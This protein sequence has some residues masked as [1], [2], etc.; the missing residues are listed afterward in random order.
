M[1]I[2]RLSSRGVVALLLAAGSGCV[3]QPQNTP[4]GPIGYVEPGTDTRY[5]IYVPSNYTASRTWPL[6]ITLH[7]THG[8]DSYGGQIR[9]WKMLAEEFGFLV[10]A[11]QLRSTQGVLPRIQ[12]LWYADLDRDEQSILAVLRDVRRL[13]R[14]DADS[15]LL[16]GFS[17]GGY[18]LIWTGLQH[19]DK[20]SML[21]ARS[22]TFDMGMID[23]IPVTQPARRLPV[24]ILHGTWDMAGGQ[25]SAG[26]TRLH[27][28]GFAAVERTLSGGHARR[29][30]LALAVWRDHLAMRDYR[31]D[32]A[33]P[34]G[35]FH[36]ASAA[37]LASVA[38]ASVSDSSRPAPRPAR[39]VAPR[40]PVRPPSPARAGEQHY[41][42]RQGDTLW[43]IAQSRLGSGHRW[44]QLAT[45]NPTI[46]P[47]HLA[48]GQKL[49]LPS[50]TH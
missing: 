7:G 39:T 46:Q 30:D 41:V 2:R 31:R 22:C 26:A 32:K 11:P 42:V 1:S 4:V 43:S 19:P 16:T 21:I 10:A 44:R 13:Y 15:V 47:E 17:A 8:F 48:V 33:G 40:P 25:S 18:P 20:F 49:R 37:A 3:T 45:L 27:R 5:D 36:R 50:R 24:E 28:R 34:R 38:M 23:R 12:S 35:L 6:V 14:I 9:E 29:P